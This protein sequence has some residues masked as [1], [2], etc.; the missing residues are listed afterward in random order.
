LEEKPQ[1]KGLDVDRLKEIQRI[2][3]DKLGIT[4]ESVRLESKASDLQGWDSVNHI[5][6]ITDIEDTF[7]FKFGLEEIGEMNSVQKLLQA[8]ESK[9]AS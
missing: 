8:V 7:D 1:T 4:P 2:I 6:I 3:A 5:M 9:S